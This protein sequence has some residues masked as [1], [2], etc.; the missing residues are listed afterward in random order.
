VTGEVLANPLRSICDMFAKVAV[1]RVLIRV[2]GSSLPV[3]RKRR[4]VDVY[5]FVFVT[6]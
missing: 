2:A 1:G 5:L 4:F 3:L 6:S